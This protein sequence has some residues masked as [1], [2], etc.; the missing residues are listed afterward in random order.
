MSRAGAEGLGALARHYDR[1]MDHVD[2]GRWQETAWTLGALAPRPFLH[3][4]VAC[5]TGRLVRRLRG[6]GWRSVGVDL[7][8]SM[9]RAGRRGGA[10]PPLAAADMRALPVRGSVSL[11]TCLFDSLNFLLEAGDAQRAIAECAGS[12]AR[13]GLFYFDVVTERMVKQHFANRAW[14][15]QHGRFQTHWQSVYDPK[16]KIASTEVRV[17]S[18]PPACIRERIYERAFLEEA[19][20][21]AGL[22]LLGVFDAESWKAP[23]KRSIRLDFVAAKAPDAA[24]RRGF[25]ASA[26][27]LRDRLRHTAADGC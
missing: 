18:H 17:N 3:L 11:A 26:A 21:A 6:A 9:L 24:L 19:V 16:D 4:D 20:R 13:G 14:H 7:S 8:L 12:L 22:E 25:Q 10:G 23:G 5:G 1:I 15:E 2:Y 27:G